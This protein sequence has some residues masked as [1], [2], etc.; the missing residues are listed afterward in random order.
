MIV[1]AN[2]G[3]L[4]LVDLTTMGDSVKRGDDSTIGQFDSGLKYAL[5]IL[6][7]SGV[8]VEILSGGISYEIGTTII[9]PDHKAKEVLTVNG[10]PTAFS[11]QLGFNWEPWMA[12]RELYSNCIDEGGEV[13]FLDDEDPLDLNYETII[14]LKGSSLNEEM[15]KDWGLYFLDPKKALC[16]S[17]GVKVYPNN[18]GHLKLYKSGI[19]IYED[20]NVDSLFL[21]DDKH[22]SIDERRYLNDLYSLKCNIGYSLS[23]CE[24]E[25]VVTSIL[26][27]DH[28]L[29]EDSVSFSG[30]YFG[31]VWKRCIREF[32]EKTPIQPNTLISDLFEEIVRNNIIDLGFKKLTADATNYYSRTRTIKVAEETPLTFEE[33]IREK[34]KPFA[35]PYPIKKSEISGLKC[36]PD[37]SSK[38]L[39]VTEDFEK[40]D[41]WEM[42]KAVFR[43]ASKDKIDYVYK[44]Y[45]KLLK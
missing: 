13:F 17:N 24:Y 7:R 20:K 19:L 6:Y 10:E 27:C 9:T 33:E 16:E 26:N 5:A 35:I 43:I 3:K 45:V 2:N 12:Y 36:L 32:N 22:A 25:E 11:P 30:S 23:Q 40:D 34:C 39:Y 44:E 41:L 1:F 14:Q 15:I 38:T 8:E 31:D 18:S 37:I 4:S 28:S 29:F 42:V 21:Y